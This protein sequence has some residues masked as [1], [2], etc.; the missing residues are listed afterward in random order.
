MYA[1][2]THS[3]N[4]IAICSLLY[5]SLAYPPS[6]SITIAKKAH[7]NKPTSSRNTEITETPSTEV[8]WVATNLL[9][10]DTTCTMKLEK[11]EDA[12][13]LMGDNVIAVLP[14]NDQR[15][16]W[17]RPGWVCIYYYPFDVGFSLP[18]PKLA[19]DILDAHRIAPS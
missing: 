1:F 10:D 6:S 14:Q 8:T 7:A 19:L 3:P 13:M 16:D 11:L 2:F 4:S 17:Y 12:K 15:A 9:D 5:Y 18:Y